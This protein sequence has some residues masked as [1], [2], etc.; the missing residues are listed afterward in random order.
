MLYVKCDVIHC[1]LTGVNRRLIMTRHAE[2]SA[3]W[4]KKDLSLWA[5]FSSRKLGLRIPARTSAARRPRIPQLS[6]STFWKVR[7]QFFDLQK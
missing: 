7:L 1:V 4:L 2:V 6:T 3:F 5:H